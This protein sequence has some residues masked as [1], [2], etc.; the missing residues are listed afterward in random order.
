MEVRIENKKP[1]IKDI[2]QWFKKQEDQSPAGKDA[3]VLK[4]K[5]LFPARG[6]IKPE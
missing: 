2:I 4:L 1:K 5:E 3:L 6:Y